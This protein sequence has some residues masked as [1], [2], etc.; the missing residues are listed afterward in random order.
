MDLTMAARPS[1]AS[2]AAPTPP[3]SKAIA[4]STSWSD[5]PSELAG[6]VLRRFPSL[7]DRVRFG[8]VC[9]QWRHAAGQQAP[10]LPPVLPWT[11]TTYTGTFRTIPD[12]EQHVHRLCS[13]ELAFCTCTSENLLLVAGRTSPDERESRSFLENPLSGATLP[14]PG[15]DKLLHLGEALFHVTKFIVC[16]DNLFVATV[17]SAI[18]PNDP[19][20]ACCRLGATSWSTSTQSADGHLSCYEDI[21]FHDHKIYAITKRGS[22]FTHE[23]SEDHGYEKPTVLSS[24]KLVINGSDTWCLG[25]GVSRF[26]VVSHGDRL[27]MV[28]WNHGRGHNYYDDVSAFEV[29]EADLQMSR[30]SRLPGIDDQVLFVSPRCSKAVDVSPNHG[31]YLCGNRIYFMDN[32]GY[33]PQKCHFGT[34]SCG[35]YDLRDNTFHPIMSDRLRANGIPPSAWFFPQK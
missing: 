13:S 34:S 1:K 12:G 6:L 3:P 16:P 33:A 24:T 9:R 22:L 14:L 26:L 5:L 11:I 2:P 28:Q 35:M 4:R 23:V 19:L 17:K 7:A 20:I 18:L 15:R 30:W 29:F 31:D 21:A 10:V 32:G 8:S 25:Q 27:L